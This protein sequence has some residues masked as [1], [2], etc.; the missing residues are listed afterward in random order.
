MKNREFQHKSDTPNKDEKTGKKT[1]T[2]KKVLGGPPTPDFL[3]N[4]M[5]LELDA[6]SEP[7]KESEHLDDTLI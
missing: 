4:P 3:P 7:E 6:Q 2:Q 5:A 1:K